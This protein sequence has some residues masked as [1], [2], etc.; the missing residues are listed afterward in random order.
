MSS[1]T[2]E[3]SHHHQGGILDKVKGIYHQRP[4]SRD[5][6][7]SHHGGDDRSSYRGDGSS[8]APTDGE[9]GREGRD[10]LV[11]TGRGGAGNMRASSRSRGGDEFD[12]SE[13]EAR[14]RSRE[15]SSERGALGGRGGAGNYRS[16]SKSVEE[17]ARDNEQARKAEEEERI[18]QEKRMA[19]ESTHHHSYGRGGAG[20]V[21]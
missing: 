3:S 7:G 10:V 14:A 17:R 20:N 6:N 11:S 16:A 13:A 1:G 9:R 15:R 18:A 12:A 21:K 8:L 4:S 5:R 19:E 2:H